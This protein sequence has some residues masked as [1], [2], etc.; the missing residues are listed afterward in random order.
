MSNPDGSVT[1]G[2]SGIRTELR[3]LETSIRNHWPIPADQLAG[4][5]ERMLKLVESGS[6]R[7]AVAAARVL[8]AMVNANKTTVPVTSVHLHNHEPTKKGN[9][10]FE[11]RREA[12]RARNRRMMAVHSS[13]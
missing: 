8:V 5:P 10:T 2:G 13:E 4:V 11:E 7:E 12:L 1:H 3:D 6:A 9:M